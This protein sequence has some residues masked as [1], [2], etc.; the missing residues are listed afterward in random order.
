MCDD[1]FG[2]NI[3]KQ[4]KIMQSFMFTN[5]WC[6]SQRGSKLSC[7]VDRQ[8]QLARD[9]LAGYMTSTQDIQEQETNLAS[10]PWRRVSSTHH[11]GDLK[12]NAASNAKPNTGS[13]L[14]GLVLGYILIAISISCLV[15]LVPVAACVAVRS[16]A[17]EWKTELFLWQACCA[18]IPSTTVFA[19]IN[20]F[21]IKLFKHNS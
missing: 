17:L 8:F 19:F 3:R 20:W 13:R 12:Q 16:C 21:S 9:D 4:V 18:M 6:S 5:L 11:L 15:A 7:L 14:S 10:L 2:Y 1:G